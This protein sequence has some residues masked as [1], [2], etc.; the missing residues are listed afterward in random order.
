LTEPQAKRKKKAE[1][2]LAKKMNFERRTI[3]DGE[4]IIGGV[5][6]PTRHQ[7]VEKGEK[8]PGWLR[9]ML[10]EWHVEEGAWCPK[11]KLGGRREV[12]N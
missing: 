6:S 11:K 9:T 2:G 8:R 7:A 1:N 10:G 12:P 3:I 5:T 4:D